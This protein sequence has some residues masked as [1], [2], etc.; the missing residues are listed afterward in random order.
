MKK[1]FLEKLVAE[2]SDITNLL[3]LTN[4]NPKYDHV[5]RAHTKAQT[6]LDFLLICSKEESLDKVEEFIYISLDRTYY[7]T[8]A[9]NGSDYG[10][11]VKARE[12]LSSL[13]ELFNYKK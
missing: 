13:L 2:L 1:K 6:L 5:I 9:T 3:A 10:Y 11:V 4:A 12:K 8:Y 7:Y